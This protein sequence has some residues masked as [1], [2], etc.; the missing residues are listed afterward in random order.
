M[1]FL[2]SL[3]VTALLML[4]ETVASLPAKGRFTFNQ[5]PSIK[6]RATGPQGLARAYKRFGAAVPDALQTAADAQR[7]F[8]LNYPTAQDAEYYALVTIG[9]QQFELDF[10]TGST[11]T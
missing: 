2:S 1:L 11:D 9:G 4:I 8:V 5:T 6:R 7:G 3:F 10:D